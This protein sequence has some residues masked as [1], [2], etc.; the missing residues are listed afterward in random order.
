MTRTLDQVLA[1][2]PIID[3]VDLPSLLRPTQIPTIT[4]DV[5]ARYDERPEVSESL[6]KCQA[7][8]NGLNPTLLAAVCKLWKSSIV[9]YR[10]TPL[11]LMSPHRGL[12]CPGRWG[13]TGQEQQ[14][15]DMI[16]PPLWGLDFVNGLNDLVLHPF[17]A[18]RGNG[19]FLRLSLQFAVAFESLENPVWSISALLRETGVQCPVLNLLS[20]DMDKSGGDTRPVGGTGGR[21]TARTQLSLYHRLLRYHR[22]FLL[23]NNN[24]I[25]I[26]AKFLLKLGE[27][28]ARRMPQPQRLRDPQGR[29]PR[30]LFYVQAQNLEHVYAAADTVSENP[31]TREATSR[32]WAQF[33][34]SMRLPLDAPV[35]V[36]I[37]LQYAYRHE[38]HLLQ[39]FRDAAATSGAVRENDA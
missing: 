17:F 21:I 23:V 18:S 36:G 6:R 5:K 7:L 26:E 28:V 25:S 39:A 34:E 16:A 12:C 9:V 20:V 13:E 30:H 31:Q 2:A 19:A 4:P 22:P 37:C 32:S 38:L 29:D 15:A 3:L 14:A 33:N 27:E 24:V 8:F 11:W 1:E 10:E 35:L